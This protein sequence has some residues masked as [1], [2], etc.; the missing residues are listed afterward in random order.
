MKF[1]RLDCLW[2]F[3]IK[4]IYYY[5]R[6]ADWWH[7]ASQI[8]HDRNLPVSII[9][10]KSL[11]SLWNLASRIYYD[12]LATGSLSSTRHCPQVSSFIRPCGLCELW[13]VGCS[14]IVWHLV[15]WVRQEAECCPAIIR[16]VSVLRLDQNDIP[17]KYLWYIA[18]KTNFGKKEGEDKAW[19]FDT[20]TAQVDGHM[21][22]FQQI[23]DHKIFGAHCIPPSVRC[24]N[25]IA[26]FS[27]A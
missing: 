3:T 21:K 20:M 10:C 18:R 27:F 17:C 14:V 22:V 26:S 24:W 13:P 4:L 15:A 16:C 23:I 8:V 11:L 2:S 5:D 1:C 6:K 9:N 7:P 25:V 19:S 12:R